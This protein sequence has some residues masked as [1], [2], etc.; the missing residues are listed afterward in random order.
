MLP[1]W[2]ILDHSK[3][4]GYCVIANFLVNHFTALEMYFIN[5]NQFFYPIV[6]NS[7]GKKEKRLL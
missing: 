5:S 6:I 3:M 2:L 4:V 1:K 7:E